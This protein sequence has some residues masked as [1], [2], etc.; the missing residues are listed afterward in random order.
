MKIEKIEKKKFGSRVA[1]PHS[2]KS[3]EM[4]KKIELKYEYKN[5]LNPISEMRQMQSLNTI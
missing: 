4:K 1:R 2:A 3:S 5:E